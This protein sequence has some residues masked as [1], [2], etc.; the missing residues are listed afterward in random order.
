VTLLCNNNDIEKFS[1]PP[2]SYVY[3]RKSMQETYIRITQTTRDTS[4]I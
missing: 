2:V 3:I 1:F 4:V